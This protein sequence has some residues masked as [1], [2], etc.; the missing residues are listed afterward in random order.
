[1]FQ[2]AQGVSITSGTGFLL[3]RFLGNPH[4]LARHS[5][6]T[7]TVCKIFNLILIILIIYWL[8]SQIGSRKLMKLDF[9][10]LVQFT[11]RTNIIQSIW[12]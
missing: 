4:I 2:K 11:C 7:Q 5:T 10:L 12:T 6:H 1:M 8:F 9:V 3:Y